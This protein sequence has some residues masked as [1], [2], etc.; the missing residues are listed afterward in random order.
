MSIINLISF[1]L[2]LSLIVII[3]EFGHLATAKYFGVYCE[4]FAIGMGPR[5]IKKQIGETIYSIR[6]FPLGGFVS[7]AG[8]EG[9]DADHIPFERTIKGIA[10]WKQVIVM[11]A[12]AIMNIILAW[13][14]FVSIQ[15]INGKVVIPPAPIIENIVENSPAQ[16]AGLLKGDQIILLS[17]DKESLE[18]KNYNDIIEY[19]SF[20]PSEISTVKVLRDSQTLSFQV[21]P[22]LN[23]ENNKYMIGII[24][25]K[26]QIESINIFESIKYGTKELFQSSTSIFQSLKRLIRGVGVENLSGPIGIF[27]VSSQAVEA[28]FLPV[29]SLIALLSLN[30]GIF[31]L[32]PLPVLD[33]GRIFITIGEK[34][35]GKK[36][37]SKAESIIMISGVVLLVGIM[38]FATFQDLLRIF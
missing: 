2:I 32:L 22:K 36:L 3:H 14:L 31:N 25:P 13:G 5:I 16:V 38:I 15:I 35:I 6:A 4:E 30:I 7:M 10:W 21:E 37:G 27:Q 17:N 23:K 18:P 33:G 29:L 24:A 12:G 26:P 11:A 8:E 9:I 1:L 28:G 19:F 20:Y 34:L